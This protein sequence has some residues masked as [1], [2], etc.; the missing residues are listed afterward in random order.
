MLSTM[1]EEFPSHIKYTY[2][3]GGMFTWVE[4]PRGID[5]ADVLKNLLNIR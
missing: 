1:K 5:A 2:P 3:N 4:L